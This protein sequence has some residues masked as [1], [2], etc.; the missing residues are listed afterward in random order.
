MI[1]EFDHDFPY[2]SYDRGYSDDIEE[3]ET[4][5]YLMDTEIEAEQ[6]LPERS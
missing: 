1:P 4:Q 3:N 5:S 2:S 6:E